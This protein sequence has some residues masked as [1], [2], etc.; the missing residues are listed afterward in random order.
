MAKTFASDIPLG[1]RVRDRVS[2]FEGITTC[3]TF[4]L[5][6]CTR[7]WVE[8]RSPAPSNIGKPRSEPRP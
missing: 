4:H 2:Q 3:V 5:T 8:P 1:S 7:H 6:G